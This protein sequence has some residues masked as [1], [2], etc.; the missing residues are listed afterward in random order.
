MLSQ[1]QA[2]RIIVAEPDAVRRHQIAA[3]LASL[4]REVAFCEDVSNVTEQIASAGCALVIVGPSIAQKGS[5][6]EVMALKQGAAAPAVLI[7]VDREASGRIDDVLAAGADVILNPAPHDVL[8]QQAHRLIEARLF[9]QKAQV[10]ALSSTPNDEDRSDFQ[11]LLQSTPAALC[12]VGKDGELRLWNRA[13]ESLFTICAEHWRSGKP[14]YLNDCFGDHNFPDLRQGNVSF[15]DYEVSLQAADGTLRYFSISAAPLFERN[16][17]L[18]GIVLAVNDISAFRQIEAAE[19]EQRIFAEALRDTASALAQ[20]LDL[21][22]VMNLI[23][24]NVG[25]VVPHEK[26]NIMLIDEDAAR[27]VYS[28]GYEEWRQ[29]EMHRTKFSLD[30]PTLS[31]MATTGKPIVI[32]DTRQSTLW[33]QNDP[34]HWIRSYVATPIRAYNHVIGFLNLDSAQPNAFTHAD[35]ERLLAFANQAAIAI[36]NAQLYS[37]I[38]RDAAELRAL[39]RATAFLFNA[40]LL[41]SEDLKEVCDRIVN[42]II[43]EFVKVDCGVLLYEQDQLICYASTINYPLSPMEALPVEPSSAFYQVLSSRNIIHR[44]DLEPF[45]RSE[46]GFQSQLIIPLRTMKDV[47]GVI[48]LRGEQSEAFDQNDQRILIAFAERAGAAIA[49]MHLYNEIQRRV[50]ERTAELSRVKERAEAILNYTSDSIILLRTDG[51]FQQTNHAFNQ[52]FSVLPDQL[53]GQRFDSIA[54]PYYAEILGRAFEEVIAKRQPTRLEI[55]AQRYDQSTFD[56]DVI[57]SPIIV[58]NQVSSVIC[59]LRDNSERKRLEVELRDALAKERELN[60]LKSR[61]IS[62]VSHE[63]RTPLAMIGTAADMLRNYNDRMT[64]EQRAEKLNRLQSEVK[65]LADLLDD[66]LTLSKTEEIGREKFHPHPFDLGAMCAEVLAEMRDGIGMHHEFELTISGECQQIHA[67]RKLIRRAVVNLLSNAVKYSLPGSKISL[68]VTCDAAQTVLCVQDTG[69]GIP[70][71]DLKHLFEAF[72]RGRNV[73]HIAGTGLGLAIVKQSVELHG[74][75]ITVSSQ[76]GVGSAFT[77]TLPHL[78]TKEETP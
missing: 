35:A 33:T 34:T 48:D 4:G 32:P 61:F 59:S 53:Y 24:D 23:L 51:T 8:A 72:Y 65:N 69:I 22:S 15:H 3:A 52:M 30:M 39:H 62:R 29:Q 76:L 66:L 26:A 1:Q 77:M 21:Q 42:A 40:N 13:F 46:H 27:V 68:S 17:E 44:T 70:E 74:G 2:E 67:D 36:E 47:C 37:A 28:R 58:D 78:A 49:N 73:D 57:L 12:I 38:Y 71:E 43:N 41:V 50:D 45:G 18:T 60:E 6:A 56:A 11:A 63:F 55:I 9:T 7:M 20:T 64:Y 14:I 10:D 16:H 31:F 75:E 25:R 54:G 19:R 5:L